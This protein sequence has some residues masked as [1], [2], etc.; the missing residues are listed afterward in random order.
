VR[1][2]VSSL[3]EPAASLT[4]VSQ[5]VAKAGVKLTPEFG[6]TEDAEVVSWM[7]YTPEVED[8]SGQ[9]DKV[10]RLRESVPGAKGLAGCDSL[11]VR[12]GRG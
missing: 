3:C 5:W 2:N 8:Q 6:R 10:D 12:N 11:R 4:V 1:A 9:A 7:R